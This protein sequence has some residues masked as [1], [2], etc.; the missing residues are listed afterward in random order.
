MSQGLARPVENLISEFMKLPS[1]GQ[2]SAQ[3]L[4]YHFIG[5]SRDEIERLC[6]ALIE[7][8]D[9]ICECR[10]CGNLSEKPVCPI[11]SNPSRDRNSICAVADFRD[12]AAI[13]KTGA[14]RGLYFVLGGLI[15]PME[16]V[17]PAN[18]RFGL[19]KEKIDKGFSGEVIIA[20]NPT[21]NGETTALYIVRLL[22]GTG[23]KVSRL[24]YGLPVGASLEY[25]DEITLSRAIAGRKEF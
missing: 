8:K 21:V 2:K 24:A 16:G 6:R 3:R 22:A 25:A 4:A 15:S 9:R 5:R 1:V 10:E 14:Y 17:G 19:L 7:V 13:E 12:V 23:V 18:L 11:C 20:T